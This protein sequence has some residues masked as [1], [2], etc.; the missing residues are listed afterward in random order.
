MNKA[1][2]FF[3]LTLKQP[4][5]FTR[6]LLPTCL[7]TFKPLVFFLSSSFHFLPDP[8]CL[9]RLT[10]PSFDPGSAF[11]SPFFPELFGIIKAFNKTP[12][13]PQ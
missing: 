3:S 5:S 12:N 1:R 4:L 7:Y 8:L 11:A 6:F 13:V 10:V 9:A 2:V